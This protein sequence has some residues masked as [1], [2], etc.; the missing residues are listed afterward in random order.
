MQAVMIHVQHLLGI[1]HLM[2]A[3]LIAEALADGGFDTHL[4]SGGRTIGGRLP[5]GVRTVQLP[6]IHVS[7]GTLKPLRDEE[8]RP[9]DDAYRRK[10][11]DLL[12]DTYEA[13]APDVVLFETFPFGRRALHFEL[14]PLLERIESARPRPRVVASV[15][16]ILQRRDNVERE[17]EM[18]ASAQRWFDAVLVHG[19][20]RFTRLEETFALAPELTMPVHYTGFVVARSE[21]PSLASVSVS[22]RSEVVVS[23]GGG[24]VGIGLF[25]AALAAQKRSRYGHLR[26]RVLVGPNVPND[27]FQRLLGAAG[28]G[29]IVE[30][31]REDFASLLGQALISVSQAGY[32]T[33]LDVVRSGA[34]P[35]VVPFTEDGET[36]QRMRANRLRDLE[37]AVV[38]DDG[39]VSPAAL[40]GAIDAAGSREKWGRWDFDCDGAARSA[41]LIAAMI[42]AGAGRR[43]GCAT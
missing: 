36:E 17:R 24:T 22:G 16:D 11:R 1:G 20:R 5:R 40:A 38:V 29:A 7:D 4:V 25:A 6:P 42:E 8:G 39:T 9:I 15:R 34:R 28:P 37:L 12:L 21:S 14:M 43:A 32:N 35:V 27:D 2:R 41:A 19:D 31:A 30:R 10:R 13:V 23:A 26:W 3:R 18:L 33:V